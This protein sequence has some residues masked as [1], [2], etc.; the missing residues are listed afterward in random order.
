MIDYFRGTLVSKTLNNAVVEVNG[1][2]YDVNITVSS[3]EKLPQSGHE[4]KLYIVEST[5]MYGGVVSHYGFL[6]KEEREMFL[7]IKDEVPGTGAKKTMEYM[8]KISKSFADF[9]NAVAARD[10][11]MLSGIFGFTKKTAEKLVA[12]LKDKISGIVVVDSQKWAAVSGSANV[13]EAIAG[14][15]ALGYKEFQA[16][17][18]VSK[19]IK[20]NDKFSVESI[21]KEALKYL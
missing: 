14:L 9:K 2:G 1:T 7:L 8:D 11:S 19:I 17:E 4:I 13:S 12:A 21:I 6:S 16:R 3:S 10:V 5:G 20:E 15:V 18:T